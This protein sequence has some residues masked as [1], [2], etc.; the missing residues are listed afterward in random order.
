MK[1]VFFRA[2]SSSSS[3]SVALFDVVDSLIG[4]NDSGRT[5]NSS[6]RFA[7]FEGGLNLTLRRASCQSWFPYLKRIN[8]HSKTT[9][10]VC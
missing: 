3:G 10:L 7:G 4:G 5:V 9:V 2:W 6:A 1:L 8:S